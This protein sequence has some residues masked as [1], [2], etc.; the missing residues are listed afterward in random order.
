MSSAQFWDALAPHHSRIENNY[1]DLTSVRRIVAELQE[2]VLVVGAGQGLLVAELRKKG[3]ECDGVDFSA[4]MIRYAKSRRGL[5]LVLADAR[6]L[7]FADGTY[8][9]VVYA[10]GVVDFSMDEAAVRSMLKEGTRVVRDAGKI[11]IGFY[12]ISGAQERFLK[13]VGLLRDNVLLHREC[14]RLYLLSPAQMLGWVVKRAGT[15]Y[16]GAAMLLLQLSALGA[17]R[18]IAMTFRMQK[19]F[20][21]LE[22]PNVL[23]ESAQEKHPYRNEAEIRKLFERLAIP[24]KELRTFSSCWILEVAVPRAGGT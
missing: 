14:F 8:G 17:L 1:F 4:E 23:I 18:E 6:A 9:T 16:P 24:L 22:N 13:R 5:E 21:Q 11:F 15:S 20:R 19:I 12:R 3:V 7:P 2:P 10:T